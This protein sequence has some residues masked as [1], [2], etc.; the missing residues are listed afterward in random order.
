MKTRLAADRGDA[1]AVAVAADAAHHAVHQVLHARRVQRGESRQA[2]G[3]APMVKMS[4]RMPP[5]PV[6]APWY[7]SMYDGWLCDSILN[8]ATQPSPMS[9]TPA[10]SP[11]PCTT[12][13]PEVGKLSRCTR[14]DL[15][16]QGSDHIT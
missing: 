12:C 14:L 11:G 13:G 10:F 3:R 7:G 16:E 9:I 8:A 2:M 4:R 15:Y 1:D 5:T 6:A